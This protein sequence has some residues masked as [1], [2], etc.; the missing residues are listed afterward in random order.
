[1]S[2]A[3]RRRRA[4]GARPQGHDDGAARREGS[5]VAGRLAGNRLRI[6]HEEASVD[7][8]R[9]GRG[10]MTGAR[11]AWCAHGKPTRR[12]SGG[13]MERRGGG[14]GKHGR[15]ELAGLPELDEVFQAGEQAAE[16]G[17]DQGLHRRGQP[18]PGAI[19]LRGVTQG[20]DLVRQGGLMN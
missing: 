17:H 16:A 12:E 7:C 13:R 9:V 14:G 10:G 18:A 5:G 20:G 4:R 6:I 11:E 8:T 1:M 3:C 19:R 15:G 2:G